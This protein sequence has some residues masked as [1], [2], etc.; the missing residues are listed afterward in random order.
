MKQRLLGAAAT[1]GMHRVSHEHS[2]FAIRM[3][4]KIG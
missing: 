1:C 2:R 4:G 3:I